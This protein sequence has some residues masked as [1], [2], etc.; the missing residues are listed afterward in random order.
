L[1]GS[2]EVSPVEVVDHFLTRIDQLNPKVK[3]IAYVNG[4]EA[5]TAAKQSEAAVRRGEDLGPLHGVPFIPIEMMAVKGMPWCRFGAEGFMSPAGVAAHD[6]IVVERLRRSGAIPIASAVMPSSY[7][8]AAHEADWAL[9]ARNPWDLDRVPGQ[10]SSG[11]GSAAAAAFAPIVLAADGGGSGRLPASFSGVCSFQPAP[12]RIPVINPEAPTPPS[13]HGAVVSPLS[14]S[15][16]DLAIVAQAIVGP[17]GRDPFCYPGDAPDYLAD[18]DEGVEGWKFAWTGDF[19]A[20][21]LG[22]TE[23]GS[24]IISQVRK[25]AESMTGAGATINP[26]DEVWE[27]PFVA[28]SVSAA[29]YSGQEDFWTKGSGLPSAEAVERALN[30][31]KESF[32]KFRSLFASNRVLI[33]PTV[34]RVAP[35]FDDYR[36]MFVKPGETSTLFHW[37]RYANWLG[38]PAMSVPAGFV[39]GLPVGLQ[40]IGPPNGEADV[41]RAAQAFQSA[42][43]Q[44]DCAPIR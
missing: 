32:D 2:G 8:N 11:S 39:D 24:R 4:D 20:T 7:K 40:I 16:R 23:E 9:E 5:R 6:D 26:T 28:T 37:L 33:T 38:L 44:N 25:A 29:A 18:L 3:A 13:L 15:V 41:L 14:R 43:P 31:R 36:A 21:S 30:V 22:S 42:Y 1:I 17:D 10:S 34:L 12:N 27:D 35:H 19:G